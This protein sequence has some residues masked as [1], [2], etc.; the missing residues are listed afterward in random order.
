MTQ[1]GLPRLP[2]TWM[3]PYEHYGDMLLYVSTFEYMAI[4]R[5]HCIGILFVETPEWLHGLV[6][7]A[8][9]DIVVSS[10]WLKSQF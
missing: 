8:S 4:V 9:I 6:K 7:R 2:D 3:T 10:K 1:V 5:V